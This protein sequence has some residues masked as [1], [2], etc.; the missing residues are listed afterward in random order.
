MYP[1]SDEKIF[2]FDSLHA[3]QPKTSRKTH[4]RLLYDVLQLA[5]QRRD[6]ACAHKAWSILIR[7]KEVDWKTLWRTGMLLVE[8]ASNEVPLDSRKLEYLST[9]MLQYPEAVSGDRIL[10]ALLTRLPATSNFPRTSFAIHSF[11]TEQ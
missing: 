4:I 9:M 8:Q 5:I 6:Y 2:I 1:R 7:C 11:R 3:R 10:S